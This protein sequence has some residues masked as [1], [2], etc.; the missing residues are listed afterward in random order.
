MYAL[1]AM[2]VL[3]SG[4][5]IYLNT[6]YY[7]TMRGCETVKNLAED[8][9]ISDPKLTDYRLRCLKITEEVKYEI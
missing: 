1:I 6:T 8:H 2:V 3:L 7:N 9:L 4:E 5:P